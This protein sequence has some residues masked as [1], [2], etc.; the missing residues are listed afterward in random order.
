MLAD[1]AVC[2][3]QIKESDQ[4][5]APYKKIETG[6]KGLSAAWIG[7]NRIYMAFMGSMKEPCVEILVYTLNYELVKKVR[8]ED[9]M[10]MISSMTLTPDEKYLVCAHLQIRITVLN[11]EDFTVKSDSPFGGG[12]DVENF[13]VWRV[14]VTDS[15]K[16]VFA[17]SDGL[18]TG[19]ISE[20]GEFEGED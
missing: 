18:Y 16:L 1:Q 9:T 12:E 7:S 11:T 8:L 2:V 6:C 17:T 10:I 13:S 4:S 14:A 3:Y 19:K 20:S 5:P 15:G